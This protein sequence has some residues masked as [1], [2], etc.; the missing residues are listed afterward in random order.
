MRAGAGAVAGAGLGD[1]VGV[2][3]C[4]LTQLGRS[5]FNFGQFFQKEQ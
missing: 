4:S 5:P 3:G 1:G 2:G